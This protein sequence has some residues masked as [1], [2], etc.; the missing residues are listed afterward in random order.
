MQDHH[1]QPDT[2]YKIATYG[3]KGEMSPL[4]D[5]AKIEYAQKLFFRKMSQL[6]KFETKFALTVRIFRCYQ[7]KDLCLGFLLIYTFTVLARKL[8]KLETRENGPSK[9][10]LEVT[11]KTGK[12][13]CCDD[14]VVE[15][16]NTLSLHHY[17]VVTIFHTNMTVYYFIKIRNA[18]Y[19]V[20]E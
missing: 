11:Q 6:Q 4:G 13:Y 9:C 19:F 8:R 20:M 2:W 18:K 5:M 1:H 17:I 3:A 14:D 16:T 7:L 10:H 12:P 15:T